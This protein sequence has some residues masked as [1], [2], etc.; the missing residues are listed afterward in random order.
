VLPSP[1]SR[2]R[3]VL[4]PSDEPALLPAS[5]HAR[6]WRAGPAPARRS[7]PVN[8][9]QRHRS[10]LRRHLAR[11]VAHARRGRCPGAPRGPCCST[12][13]LGAN[14][15][16]QWTAKRTSTA[17]APPAVGC[18]CQNCLAGLSGLHLLPDHRQPSGQPACRS[19]L[20]RGWK[21]DVAEQ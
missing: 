17:T 12:R 13:A 18:H 2:L 19:G 5:L 10:T 6:R 1:L 9:D 20:L 11:W 15:S 7:A 4:L 8:E 14:A 21:H 3:A 16:A